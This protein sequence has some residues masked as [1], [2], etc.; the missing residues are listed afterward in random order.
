MLQCGAMLRSCLCGRGS[1]AH[2]DICA[3][4]G[5]FGTFRASAELTGEIRREMILWCVCVCVLFIILRWCLRLI[6]E[7]WICLGIE[8][9][10]QQRR[11]SGFV[12]AQ[13]AKELSVIP[14]LDLSFWIA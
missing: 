12:S 4:Q 3:P 1:S 14:H 5:S 11:V 6:P 2:T 7:T 8:L 9:N 10:G 13:Q